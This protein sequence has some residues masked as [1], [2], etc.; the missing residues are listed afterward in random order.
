VSQPTAVDA[1]LSAD[2]SRRRQGRAAVRPYLF[3]L[4]DSAHPLASSL[5][6]SLRHLDMVTIGRG[7]GR[8]WERSTDSA[9]RRL[10]IAVADHWTSS[11]HVHLRRALDRW[12]VDDAGSKNG[13]R[14]NGSLAQHAA[15]CDGDL[16]ELG[17][18]F[19]L[20]RELE[21][22][23]IE[24]AETEILGGDEPAD[25]DSA[26]LTGRLPGMAT[27]SPS[28][29][30]ELRRLQAIADTAVPVLLCGE[31]G[32]GK[33]L[34]ARAVHALSGRGAAL[35]ALNCGALPG[36][37]VESELFGY[38]KGAFSGASED[39]RG[40]VRSADGGTL[41]LDEIGDL[42]LAAQAAL[43]R[44]LQEHEVLPLGESRPLAVDFRLVAASHRDLE[45][46]VRKRTFRADLLARIAGFRLP[47]PPLR[48]RREDVGMLIATLLRRLLGERAEQAT[49]RCDAARALLSHSWPLNVRELEQCLAA[50][51]GLADGQPLDLAHLP[52]G[53][54]GGHRPAAR[55]PSAD[56]GRPD[57][58]LP[59]EPAAAELV[60]RE[61]LLCLLREHRGN[62]SV[63]ARAMGKAR[64]QIH[65]WVR[66]FDIDLVRFRD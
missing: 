47:L 42:P 21:C 64:T 34:L 3:L 20:Y 51:V 56:T 24:H 26:A 6:L 8:Q 30:C 55:P 43:L 13:T 2:R 48:Q 1:T 10:R 53:V 36:N 9:G 25:L 62:V 16:L 41:F 23:E 38:R 19:F 11:I 28:W 17:H 46:L 66:R 54:R 52:E 4:L 49:L 7:P 18:T 37:L 22:R 57:G 61:K 40:L 33:E 32:T 58:A 63:V 45:E 27:L 60:L 5:R 29:A 59:D 50:A 12:I 35:V 31:S 39:R 15:L 14:V 44:V 65:R